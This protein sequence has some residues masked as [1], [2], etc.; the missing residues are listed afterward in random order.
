MFNIF[1][2]LENVLYFGECDLKNE[3]SFGDEWKVYKDSLKKC[4][5]EVCG[6]PWKGPT[7]WPRLRRLWM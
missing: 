3:R 5:I 6:E 4:D 7:L 2:T 1:Y